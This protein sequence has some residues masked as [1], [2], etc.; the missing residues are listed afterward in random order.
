MT[1]AVPIR[2]DNGPMPLIEWTTKQFGSSF[3]FYEK[4]VLS[5]E[6]CVQLIEDIE[7]TRSLKPSVTLGVENSKTRPNSY[8]VVRRPRTN[9]ERAM[10]NR[11]IGFASRFFEPMGILP[12]FTDD[13][14]K[15]HRMTKGGYFSWHDDS[16]IMSFGLPRQFTV[17]MYLN[18]D[19]LGGYTDFLYQQLSIKPEAGMM[20]IYPCNMSHIHRGGIVL[21][22]TKYI[23]SSWLS[24][25]PPRRLF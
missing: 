8:S 19:Y 2:F 6:M 1:E 22:G 4:N 12:H 13:G 11:K 10:Q 18:D 21:E 25:K 15:Y 3:V 24:S 23:I 7:E 5:P 14:L 9:T 20:I 16:A 17:L